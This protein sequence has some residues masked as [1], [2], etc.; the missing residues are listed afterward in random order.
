M[1]TLRQAVAFAPPQPDPLPQAA[2]TRTRHRHFRRLARYRQACALL[3]ALRFLCL[4]PLL[5]STPVQLLPSVLLLREQLFSCSDAY[6]SRRASLLCEPSAAF[7]APHYA[8]HH[9]SHDVIVDLVDFPTQPPLA[10]LVELLPPEDSTALANPDTYTIVL[11]GPPSAPPPAVRFLGAPSELPRLYRSLLAHGMA[12]W[13]PPTSVRATTGVFCVPKSPTVLRLIFDGRPGNL[14]LHDPP[15]I[16]LPTPDYLTALELGPHDTLFIGKQD[17]A[18]YF[19]SLRIPD[20]LGAYYV[21]PAIDDATAEALGARA[22]CTRLALSVLPMGCSWAVYWA[23]RAHLH[24]CASVL[25]AFHPTLLARSLHSSVIDLH[26]AVIIDDFNIL[27]TDAARGCALQAALDSAYLRSRLHQKFSKRRAMTSAPTAVAGMLIDGVTGLLRP[28]MELL[29]DLERDT[30][31]LLR[32]AR[33]SGEALSAVMGGWA[34]VALACRPLFA[35]FHAVYIFIQRFFDQATPLWHSAADELTAALGLLPLVQCDLRAPWAPWALATDASEHG[36]GVVAA[37]VSAAEQRRVARA[38]VVLPE[39]LG[40]DVPF[41][42]SHWPWRIWVAAPWSF[43]IAHNTVLELQ[44]LLTG[45]S[46]LVSRPSG[47]GVR[48]LVFCD[49][50]AVVGAVAKGRS[51]ASSLSPLLRKLTAL[52]LVWHVRLEIR[53]VHTSSNPADGPSRTFRPSF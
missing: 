10:R 52:L 30:L 19:Y 16:D 11:Y 46:A 13:I 40:S 31:A 36:V 8:V 21:L 41:L 43:S 44:A 39:G 7:G 20:W 29:L 24:A 33:V 48:V 38:S 18:S 27:S 17:L 6:A 42:G 25:D 2:S 3:S 4:I 49:N 37:S 32:S 51:S 14:L 22:P 23:Q 5:P 47:Q 45:I 34:W 28:T 1:I 15:W 50:S 12:S 53:Y 26:A 9:P 35:V